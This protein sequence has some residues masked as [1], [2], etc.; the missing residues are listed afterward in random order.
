M[1]LELRAKELLQATEYINI[2]SASSDGQPWNTPA[3]GVHDKELNFYW[4]SWK[5]A[6]HS[7]FIRE[8]SRVFITL[9]DSTRKRGDNHQR[10]L[11]VQAEASE[12]EDV[13]VIKLATGLLYGPPPGGNLPSD[14]LG[15]AQRRIYRAVPLKLWLNDKSE[16]E[17]TSETLKMRV[18][19]SISALKGLL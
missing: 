15:E 3:T 4:S 13:E 6:Q 8:N 2:A 12:V 10:C 17:V 19:V 9:Y 5:N 11:Y 18:A 7:R 14:F 1:N 16:S